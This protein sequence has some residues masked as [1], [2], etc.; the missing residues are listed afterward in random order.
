MGLDT[1]WTI[2]FGEGPML[3]HWSSHIEIYGENFKFPYLDL[4]SP[5]KMGLDTDWTIP[6]GEGLM[7]HHWSSHIEIY[8]ENFKF[9]YL[10]LDSPQKWV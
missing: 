3:H 6:F 4:D 1:D 10:D 2:P 8:G 7:L 9:P 5:Q